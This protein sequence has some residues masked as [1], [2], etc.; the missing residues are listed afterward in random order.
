MPALEDTAAE[1]IALFTAEG[2]LNKVNAIGTVT[3]TAANAI[4]DPTTAAYNTATL[5]VAGAVFQLPAASQGKKLRV[6]LTQ[7]S[8]GSRTASITTSTG[9][10]KW[11][12]GSAPTLTTTGGHSDALTFECWDGTN[13]IGSAQLNVN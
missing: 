1:L 3:S 13:W 6:L 7:D 10:L 9:G 8:T 12:G 11:V 2:A 4:P 5:G